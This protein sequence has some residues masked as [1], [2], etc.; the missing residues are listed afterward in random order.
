[1]ARPTAI[2][3]ETVLVHTEGDRI[4]NVSCLTN[5]CIIFRWSNGDPVPARVIKKYCRQ[6]NNAKTTLEG[7]IRDRQR[8][9]GIN[10]L[11]FQSNDGT[12]IGI[13]SFPSTRSE[14]SDVQYSYPDRMV[15]Q[16]PCKVDNK[17]NLVKPIHVL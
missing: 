7:R 14:N 3:L 12:R 17:S 6:I 15:P 5:G 9:H 8:A 4:L 10:L 2:E 13:Y 16:T 11:T 1:M